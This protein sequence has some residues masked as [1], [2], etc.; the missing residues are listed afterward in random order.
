MKLIAPEE[1]F[2]CD[3]LSTDGTPLGRVPVKPEVVDGWRR[4]L[5]DFAEYWLNADRYF[6]MQKIGMTKV[7]ALQ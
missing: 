5:V 2:W 6:F 1:A 4:R 3:K 7:P